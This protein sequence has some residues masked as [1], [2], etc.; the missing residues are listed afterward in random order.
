MARLTGIN[1]KMKGK[2]GQWVFRRTLGQTVVSELPEKKDTP[3][4]TLAQQT[5]RVRWAN[6]VAMW[7]A[8]Q[9][10]LKPSFE[11]KP[12]NWSDFNAFTNVNLAGDANN[13][14][15]PKS[16]AK[17]GGC[18][19][20]PYILTQGSLA[21]IALELAE[22]SLRP[23]T[24]LYMDDLTID[25]ST[26][27]LAFS[28]AIINHNEGWKDGDQLTV[29][30]AQQSTD[31]LGVPRVL[32]LAAKVN[33]SL[34][35]DAANTTLH[36]IVGNLSG[37]FVVNDEGNLGGNRSILGGVAYIHSRKTK[38]GKTLVSSQSFVVNNSA[39]S[40]YNTTTALDEAIESYGG[41]NAG[42]EY[43]T[44]DNDTDANEVT[45]GGGTSG[46]GSNG[47]GSTPG[48]GQEGD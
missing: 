21:P 11:S 6:V 4:R 8:F 45:N 43:L 13:I 41:I 26:T 38:D 2:V 16:T 20:A 10:D 9:G 30:V 24:N 3:V 19:V 44:P 15:L 39:I 37:Y 42:G 18:V 29:F 33:L 31:A 28:Q 48:G 25:S 36:S 17:M 35:A 23:A 12:A 27:L 5:N 7:K 32:V 47:G 22:G 34:A 46:G 1:T 40:L 14:Y